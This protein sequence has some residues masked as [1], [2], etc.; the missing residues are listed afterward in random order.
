[1]LISNSCKKDE[2]TPTKKIPILTWANPDD[3]T[4]PAALSTLQLNATAN[5][6]GSFV[7]TP[8]I[9]SVLSIGDA[10]DIKVD[11]FPSDAANYD[12]VT[13][14]VKMNVK[15]SG[16]VTDFDGNIYNT[17]A[18][19]AQIW[20]VEN[21]KTT[22]YNDGNVIPNITSDTEWEALV[23]PAYCWYN[24]NEVTN[25]NTYGALYNW[26]AVSTDKLCPTG[27]HVPS[28]NDWSTMFGY[29]V[30]N[31]YSFDGTTTG[32]NIAKSLAATTYWVVSANPGVIGNSDYLEFRNKSGFSALPGGFR[33][34]NGVFDFVGSYGYWWS[35]TE[36]VNTGSAGCMGLYNSVS[37]YGWGNYS[38]KN[39]FSVRCVK[40]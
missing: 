39:G 1:M 7:Y 30:A 29:L 40:D 12:A 27:W 2:T 38:K 17:V 13:N 11:F 10:Q 22:R 9:G 4:F 24:N 23:T 3:I 15:A 26:Y 8:P 35:A 33:N 19:G 21:L 36:E 28:N 37:Y 32:Y 25:K 20:M 5:I 6:Q 14:V 16:S 18:I 34:D 31:N